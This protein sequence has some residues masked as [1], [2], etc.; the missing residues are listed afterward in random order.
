MKYLRLDD[1]RCH[2]YILR[3]LQMDATRERA[4]CAY[5]LIF[6]TPCLVMRSS[7]GTYFHQ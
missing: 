5:S 6:F 1:H 3:V 2:F 4:G 7:Q